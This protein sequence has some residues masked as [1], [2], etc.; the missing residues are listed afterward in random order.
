MPSPWEKGP[1][2]GMFVPNLAYPSWEEAVQSGYNKEAP[3]ASIP[4]A[5][6]PSGRWCPYCE[7]EELGW[8][9][10]TGHHYRFADVKQIPACGVRDSR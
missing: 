6:M 10:F 3:L 9:C 1:T 8:L 2:L 7:V 5:E 4:S